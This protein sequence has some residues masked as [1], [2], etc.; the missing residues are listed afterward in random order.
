MSGRFLGDLQFISFE[1]FL[2][3]VDKMFDGQI[4]F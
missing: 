4:S 2:Q 3:L 1:A